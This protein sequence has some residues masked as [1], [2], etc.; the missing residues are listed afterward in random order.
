MTLLKLLIKLRRL[1]PEERAAIRLC[2]SPGE[3]KR[4]GRKATLRLDWEKVKLTIMEDLLRQ[5]FAWKELKEKLLS[6]G[7]EELVEGNTWS[8]TFWG[9][10]NGKGEN[11]LGKLLM[12]IREELKE[13]QS[14]ELS[15]VRLQP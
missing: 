14:H 15:S 2:C 12:K 1:D 9:V 6:T 7:D 3:A 13:K 5:K 4:L 11:H 8:D 10:C